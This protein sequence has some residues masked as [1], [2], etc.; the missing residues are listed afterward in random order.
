MPRAP[1]TDRIL[2]IQALRALAAALV[3]IVHLIMSAEPIPGS[4]RWIVAIKDAAVPFGHSGVDMF[5][6]ISGA[7][8][9]IITRN[10][11]SS[12]RF[13]QTGKFLFRRIVRVYPLYW[14]TLAAAVAA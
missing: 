2:S 3:A 5:F 7:I 14:V 4:P 13:L 9:F 8:M 10:G 12:S 1:G 6:V 11:E